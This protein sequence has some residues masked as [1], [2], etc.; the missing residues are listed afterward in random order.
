MRGGNTCGLLFVLIKLLITLPNYD[1]Q[2]FVFCPT[3]LLKDIFGAESLVEIVCS[4][5]ENPVPPK[6]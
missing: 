3:D 1:G 6:T 4:C 5:S 2:N